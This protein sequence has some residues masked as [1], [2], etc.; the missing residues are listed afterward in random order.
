MTG[1]ELAQAFYQEHQLDFA[2]ASTAIATED[3]QFA[4]TA[5]SFDDFLAR[6]SLLRVTSR[7]ANDELERNGIVRLRN[8]L[9]NQ[10]NA[11]ARTNKLLGRNFTI[12]ARAKRW[13]VL[14][15][16]RY[17]AER[18]ERIAKNLE[19]G[20]SHTDRS[21]VQAAKYLERQN[22]LSDDERVTIA[23]QLAYVRMQV[24]SHVNTI[25]IVVKAIEEGEV[26]DLRVIARQFKTMLDG[27]GKKG[28]GKQIAKRRIQRRRGPEP[29]GVPA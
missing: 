23:S 13:R 24:F 19:L 4:F 14:L 9:R 22:H 3:Q 17:V 6:H 7:D 15:L 10:L 21:I 12:E 28:R 8:S 20:L 16:E 1:Y 18:P 2:R 5:D 25:R 26:P 11:A 29:Q 27:S